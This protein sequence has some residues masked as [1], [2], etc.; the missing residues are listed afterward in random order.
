MT[1]LALLCLLVG[2]VSSPIVSP[3]AKGKKGSSCKN[4]YKTRGVNGE[5]FDD[6]G[7]VTVTTKEKKITGKRD[8]YEIWHQYFTVKP[9]KGYAICK[10]MAKMLDRTKQYFKFPPAGGTKVLV[11]RENTDDTAVSSATVW[12]RD[13]R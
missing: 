3:S 13:Q 1:F 7:V 8:P 4:P 9:R 11:W 5:Y 6:R 2:G 12:S 10:V